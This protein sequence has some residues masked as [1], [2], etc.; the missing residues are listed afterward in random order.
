MQQEKKIWIKMIVYSYFL[1]QVCIAMI[2][3]QLKTNSETI[4]HVDKEQIEK[5]NI[6]LRN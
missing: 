2:Q 6:R 4:W 1:S 3:V 5:Y